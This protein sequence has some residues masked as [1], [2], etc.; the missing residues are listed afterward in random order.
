[1]SQEEKL[2]FLLLRDALWRGH[3]EPPVSLSKEETSELFEIAEKQAVSGLVIEALTRNNVGM[4]Q[5][6]IFEAVGLLELIKAQ[7]WHVNRGIIALH[8]IL[9]SEEIS[10]AIVKGQVVAS[11]YPTPLLRQS[12]D[13]DF[14]LSHEKFKLGLNVIKTEWNVDAEIHGS[15]KHADFRHDGNVFEAHFVLTDLLSPERNKYFQ[16]LVDKDEGSTV[17]VDGREIRTLSPTLHVLYV[18]LHLWYHLM[19]LGVGLRQFCD[20]AVMLKANENHN[21]NENLNLEELRGHLKALGM[22]KAYK[23]CGS[24]LVDYLGLSE[25][26]LAYTLT[27]SDRKYGKRILDVV[28]YRGNMG[29]HNKLG[30]FSGWKH[31]M[32]AMGIKLAHFVKFYPLSPAYTRQWLWHEVVR[33]NKA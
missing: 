21:E 20:L 29:H 12:G 11:Y 1:M 30:G 4:P 33:R 8:I 3:E 6:K 5:A 28:M 22:E 26:N 24:I 15:E 13:I 18:F 16:E 32:E 14:Y 25:A 31:K 17:I 23:A 2:L 19:A 7:S 9:S 10:Y 27:D